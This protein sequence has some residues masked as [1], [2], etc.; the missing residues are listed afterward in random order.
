MS[1]NYEFTA[2]LPPY[3]AHLLITGE[4]LV[5]TSPWDSTC[6]GDKPKAPAVSGKRALE[7]DESMEPPQKRSRMD[8]LEPD[9]HNHH[10]NYDDA[11]DEESEEETLE[12][13]QGRL[14]EQRRLILAQ[15]SRERRVREQREAERRA[16]LLAEKQAA[17]VALR[18]KRKE[19][20]AASEKRKHQDTPLSLPSSQSIPNNGRTSTL[21]IIESDNSESGANNTNEAT[22]RQISTAGES[23]KSPDKSLLTVPGQNPNG[24]NVQP[25]ETIRFADAGTY[26]FPRKGNR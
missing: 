1:D 5:N 12:A 13:R 8:S 7:A 10:N 20:Y 23:V 3:L 2:S 21:P 4:R 11:D 9:S 19:E 15:R 17:I 22:E 14:E 24:A 16:E 25:P 26:G 6:T 18:D